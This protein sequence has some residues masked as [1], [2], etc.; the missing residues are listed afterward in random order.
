MRAWEVLFKGHLEEKRFTQT[1]ERNSHFR[2]VHVFF[3]LSKYQDTGDFYH[4][5]SKVKVSQAKTGWNSS[6]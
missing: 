2:K 4:S 1:N 6:E 5:F 3:L